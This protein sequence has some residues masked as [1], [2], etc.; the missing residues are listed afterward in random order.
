MSSMQATLAN[1]FLQNQLPATFLQLPEFRKADR[2]RIALLQAYGG[3]WVDASILLTQ[4]LDWVMELQQTHHS[5]FVGF[6]IDRFSAH[7]ER[8][9]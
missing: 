4:P 3:I 2:L 1:S 9:L 7:K 8:R 5:E 6:D